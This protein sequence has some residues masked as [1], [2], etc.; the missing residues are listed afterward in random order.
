[1]AINRL[2]F[3]LAESLR[4]RGIEIIH[5]AGDRNLEEA[6]RRYSEL[7]VMLSYLDLPIDS[8]TILERLT[9]PSL[10]L[11]HQRYGSLQQIYALH[12][13]YHTHTLQETTNTIMVQISSG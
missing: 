13:L 9:L 11:E 1:M 3:S 8:V 6:R 7:G 5:Q 12:Y 10:E 2:A 4:D